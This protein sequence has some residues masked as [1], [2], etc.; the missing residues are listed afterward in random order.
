MRIDID[1]RRSQT[2][3]E[4]VFFH[5]VD[6]LRNET[7][8]AQKGQRAI[9]MSTIVGE[10]KVYISSLIEESNQ[11]YNNNSKEEHCVRGS[12]ASRHLIWRKDL[13]VLWQ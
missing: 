7:Q 1:I 9:T 12:R 5:V 2:N 4:W 8:F 6:P 3:K 13:I 10:A 11:N